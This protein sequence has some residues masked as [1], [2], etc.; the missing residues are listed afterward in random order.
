MAGLS[1]GIA[2]AID[3][4]T[5]NTAAAFRDRN[6]LVQEVRLSTAGSLMPSGVFYRGAQLLVGRTALQAAFTAPEAFEPS[7]KRRLSD[8]EIFLAGDMIEVTDLVAAV[9]GEVLDRAIHVM[10]SEPDSVVVTHP[11]QWSAPLQHLLAESAIAGGVSA[12]RLRLV[13]EAQAA[14]W[15]YAGLPRY[16]RRGTIDRLRLRGR[17]LRCR[18]TGKTA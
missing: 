11:E 3:F 17:H 15:F 2:L 14:A 7:P 10:G 8:R 1:D 6:G 13:S 18:G 5:S 4:G 9:F 12:R 16:G